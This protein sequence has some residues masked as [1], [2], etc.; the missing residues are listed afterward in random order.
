MRYIETFR[1]GD[2]IHDIYLC[3]TKATLMTK[4]GKQYISCLLQD[5]TGSIDGKIW[6]V[7][8]PGIADFEPLDY[9]SIVADV[10]CFNG[11][12]QLNVKRLQKA[13]AGDYEP[14]DYLPV[15]SRDRNEMYQELTA[16]IAEVKNPYLN[17]LLR[18]FF[19][20]DGPLAKAFVN[21]SAAKGVHHAFIGGLLEHSLSVAR[22][23]QF[24]L[25]RYPVLNPSLLLTAALLH[26]VGKVRELSAFPT[27][28]YT[29]EGQLV[30]HIVMGVEMIDEKIREIPDFPVKLA[31]ELRHCILAHHGE[32]EYGS[33]KKPA[34][35]EA[36]ALHLADNTDAKL[37]TMSEAIFGTPSPDGRGWL[38]F[39]RLFDTN[40]RRSG[41]W[42]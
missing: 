36:L 12:L 18:S 24:Y 16:L 34:L 10:T 23:C 32:L 25:T 39:N 8:S 15:S 9:I 21:H 41:D 28:D 26:D 4:N 38:G 2:R 22:L 40:I 14:G 37:E 3:K 19:E 42:E 6:D 20:E 31:N 11:V 33:P 7:S 1:E 35:P 13:A 29:D 30:G 5:K 27:N 17:R